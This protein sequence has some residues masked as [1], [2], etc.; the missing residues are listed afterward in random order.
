MTWHSNF[1]V[2]TVNHML[3]RISKK[4]FLK[5]HHTDKQPFVLKFMILSIVF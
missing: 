1:S 5:S 3:I 4:E 2:I